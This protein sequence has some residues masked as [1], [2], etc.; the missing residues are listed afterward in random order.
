M[1]EPRADEDLT[2]KAAALAR[3]APTEWK[4]FTESFSSY[5]AL[6]RDQCVQAP[7]EVLQNI[8]GKAQQCAAFAA[9]FGDAVVLAGRII[10]RREKS[11]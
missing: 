10:E 5:A 7:L 2:F 6:R 8:Q 4:S 11:K 9:L 3:A 1:T